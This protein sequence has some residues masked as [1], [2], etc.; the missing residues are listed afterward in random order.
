[1]P[2]KHSLVFHFADETCL[3][4]RNGSLKKLNKQINEDL[5]LLNDWLRANEISLIR[6]QDRNNTL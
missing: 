1:M 4:N 6:K 5:R 2:I 3:L